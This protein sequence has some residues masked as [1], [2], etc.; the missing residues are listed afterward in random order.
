MIIAEL[1][2]A[3]TGSEYSTLHLTSPDLDEEIRWRMDASG[4]RHI[5]LVMRRVVRNCIANGVEELM[6]DARGIGACVPGYIP[7]ELGIRLVPI[8]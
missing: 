6:Y 2:I 7:D 4:N 3:D 8:L 5:A 1:K